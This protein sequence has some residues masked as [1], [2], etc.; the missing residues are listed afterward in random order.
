M[1]VRVARET[2][3][4][5]LDSMYLLEEKNDNM[6][7]TDKCMVGGR[8]ATFVVEQYA[9]NSPIEDRFHVRF[10]RAIACAWLATVAV[11]SFGSFPRGIYNNRVTN[12]AAVTLDR[13]GVP[14]TRTPSHVASPLPAPRRRRLTHSHPN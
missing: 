1:S 7:S 11:V 6:V 2:E 3:K 14:P 10:P 13:L 5:G 4:E 8:E 12:D 9:A